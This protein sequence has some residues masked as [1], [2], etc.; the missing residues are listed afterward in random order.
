MNTLKDKVILITGANRGIGKSLVKAAL[1]K[2]AAKIY[3]TSRN[4][5]T[6]PDFA[7]QRVVTLKLDITNN[8]QL[9][10][11]SAITKDVQIL[12][13]NAGS[14]NNGTI[15][16]GEISGL[17]YDMRTNYLGTINMM[18]AFS[19][20]LESNAPSKIVNI[21]SIVAYSPLPTIAGYSASKAALFSATLSARTELAKK[22]IT[23]HTVNPGAIDTDMN[24]E[25]DWEMPSPDGIA[26]I[27]L[28]Q[29]ENGE[30]DIVPDLMGIQMFNAWKEEPSKLAGIFHDIYHGE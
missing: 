7:D 21:V 13:N 16:G 9:S 8:S 24:K 20:I 3:A 5:N 11:V 1:E 12:I 4:L 2:G 23:V 14:L 18:R 22:G 17:E 6:M 19:A 10:E 28:D 29:V 25:S 15:L 26:K 27:I 30:L